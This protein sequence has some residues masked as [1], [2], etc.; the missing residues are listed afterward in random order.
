MT[1]TLNGK[2]VAAAIKENLQQKIA[3]NSAGSNMPHLHIVRVGAR[4]DDLYYQKSLERICQSIGIKCSVKALAEDCGQLALE[5]SIKAAA[6]D[7]GTHGIL[8]FSP[9]PNGYELGPAVRLIPLSKD[10]DCLNPL[11][12]GAIYTGSQKAF[13]PC[14]AAAVMEIF[15]YYSIDLIGKNVVVVG[16]S[17]VVGKPLSM[18]LLGQNATVTI[19]H[20]KTKDL[21]ALCRSADIVIA[22][23]GR[24]KM[25]SAEYFLAGQTV[26][27]VG[28]NPDPRNPDK[29][30]GDIDYPA[31]ADIVKSITPVPGGVGSVTSAILCAHVVEA[32]LDYQG[33]N[34]D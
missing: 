31:A 11:S 24:A 1:N 22:A 15:R 29:M 10:V 30:C 20:S 18:L 33:K 8:L 25:L 27:D 28:I 7:L 26:I 12:A 19:A 4:A 32:W 21:P 16:R 6:A 23:I 34:N 17:L 14:T 5:D 2:E 3:K 13:A 9:L